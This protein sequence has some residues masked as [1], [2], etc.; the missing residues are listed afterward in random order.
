MINAPREKVW[1]ALTDVGSYAEWNP[2]TPITEVEWKLGS[3]VRQEVH[4]DLNP[5]GKAVIHKAELSVYKPGEMIGW[6]MKIGP[7]LWAE[8]VQGLEAIS[9]NQTRYFTE[10]D[11]RGI[12][13]PVVG[14]FYGKKIEYGFNGMARALKERVEEK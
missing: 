7:L 12:L 10:D 3:P 14:A 11:N 13:A 4:M 9:E 1:E 8:R 6:K 2:F 5:K